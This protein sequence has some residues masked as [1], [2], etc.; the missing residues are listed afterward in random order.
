[1][2]CSARSCTA[3]WV[4]CGLGVRCFVVTGLCSW[5][6]GSDV[7]LSCQNIFEIVSRSD[8][9][10]DITRSLL[11]LQMIR[12]GLG[13][14]PLKKNTMWK[15]SCGV[16]LQTMLAVHSCKST[17]AKKNCVGW[18]WRVAWR[19]LWSVSCQDPVTED[20]LPWRKYGALTWTMRLTR[21][22]LIWTILIHMT[23]RTNGRVGVW[24]T[25]ILRVMKR[26][27]SR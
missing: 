4:F 21:S 11:L 19:W 9:S 5:R 14:L 6:W 25:P 17:C 1:M 2:E 7:R 20:W 16:L 18:H 24:M 23:W 12:R 22:S 26:L 27:Q 13:V 3:L 8:W 15:T 10:D